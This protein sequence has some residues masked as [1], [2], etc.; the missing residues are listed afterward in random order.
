M[1]KKWVKYI[2][3]SLIVIVLFVLSFLIYKNLF[4][5]TDNSRYIGI[6]NYK[7]TNDEI[8]LV[9]D[10]ITELEEVESVDVYIDSRIIK[11]VTKINKDVDFDKMKKL[12]NKALDNFSEENLSYYD[13]EFFIE[14]KDEES[15]TYPQIGYKFKANSEFSW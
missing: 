4:A 10:E 13:I 12:A 6:E 9:K 11:I 14:S 8:N 15:K 2:I 7:L 5:G 1:L 3:L